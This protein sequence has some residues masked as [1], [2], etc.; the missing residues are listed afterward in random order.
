M[1]LN[2]TN[3]YNMELDDTEFVAKVKK[4][5]TNSLS[6]TIPIDTCDF[7]DIIDGDL[8]KFKIIKVKKGKK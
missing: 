4:T 8:V 5:G 6:I 7:C 1:I 2:N 3:L